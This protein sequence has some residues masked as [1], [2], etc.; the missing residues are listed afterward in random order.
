MN[1]KK[2]TIVDYF[3]VFLFSIIFLITGIIVGYLNV[4]KYNNEIL[5]LSY[6]TCISLCFILMLYLSLKALKTKQKHKNSLELQ[7]ERNNVVFLNN[8]NLKIIYRRFK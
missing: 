2:A 4:I 1:Y 8:K 3:L 5:N 6:F 7:K